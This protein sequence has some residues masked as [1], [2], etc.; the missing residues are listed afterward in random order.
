MSANTVTSDSAKSQ[1]PARSTAAIVPPQVSNSVLWIAAVG[2]ALWGLAWIVLIPNHSSRLGWT[3]QTVGPLLIAAAIIM[4]TKSLVARVGGAV[5]AF[6]SIGAICAGLSTVFF[7]ID[8]ENLALEGHVRFGYGGYGVGALFGAIA[9]ALVLSRKERELT[10]AGSR[11]YPPCPIG[12]ACGTIV[13][14]SFVSIATG[15]VGLL[16]W[17]I[18]FILHTVEPQGTSLGWVLSTLGV[19]LIGASFALHTDHLTQRFGRAATV[20]GIVSLLA[21]V[22]GYFLEAIHPNASPLSSWYSELFAF[23]G[24]GHLLSALAVVLIVRRKASL[25]K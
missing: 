2:F 9:L 23:Y 7:A 3:L 10:A 17:G 19:L 25:A 11:S 5:V 21:W 16:V 24:V 18:G 1:Q 15:A 22:V 4:F 20:L 13:H 6:A 12:C 8:P 14:S